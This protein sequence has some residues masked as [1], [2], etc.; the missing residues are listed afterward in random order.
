MEIIGDADILFM[1]KSPGGLATNP[2]SEPYNDGTFEG[3]RILVVCLYMGANEKINRITKD[4]FDSQCGIVLKRKGFSYT[5]VCSYG[6]GVAELLHSENERCPYIQL[7]LFSS[8]GYGNLPMEAID[9]DTNKIIPFLQAVTDFW[10][11]GGG[12]FLFCDNHPYNFEVNYLLSNY[13]SF[14]D[15]D[16]SR[17]SD[18]RLGKNYPGKQQIQVANSNFLSQ[19]TFSPIVNLSQIGSSNHRISLR[20]GL[21]RFYEGNTISYA[22]NSFE[23]PL[24]DLKDLWPF[25]PFA[26]TSENA[27]PPYPF[28]LFYDPRILSDSLA[29]GPIVL[30]GGFT[31]AFYEFGEDERG[32]G[33][34]IISV[35]CWLTRIEERLY[36]SKHLGIPLLK[37]IPKI[38]ESH[39][40]HGNFTEWRSLPREFDPRH[41]ILILDGSRS[42]EDSYDELIAAVNEYISIQVGKQGIISVIPFSSNASILYEQG[43]KTLR[44]MEGFQGEGT[45]YSEPLRLAIEIVSRN[46]PSFQCRII[47][48]TDGE[49][50]DHHYLSELETL[51]SM[52]VRIDAIGFD[53]I[54]EDMREAGVTGPDL[55]V[56][57]ILTRNSGTY[58]IGSTMSEVEN[59]FK[60][61]AATD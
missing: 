10:E 56:L 52:G 60:R 33:R 19:G 15:N 2:E 46:L 42:M 11:A 51:Q 44:T 27:S 23:T 54:A 21:I 45:K 12:L 53:Y 35:A 40:S 59:E 14:T 20:P 1:K 61:I 48:F 47:F 4:I 25:T 31:S 43:T 22:V 41:S 9:K 29:P 16:R 17:F 13:L 36:N 38:S 24:T 58:F 5:F 6:E 37:T 7:W 3:F 50:D 8:E 39:V 28:I 55:R 57:S 26:W 32:T 49:P 18:V 30:H 34:L